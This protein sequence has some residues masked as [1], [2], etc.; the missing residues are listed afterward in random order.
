MDGEV[1]NQT[2]R[3]AQDAKRDNTDA[4]DVNAQDGRTRWTHEMDAQDG[5]TQETDRRRRRTDAGDGQ[6]QTRRIT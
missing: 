5:Q 3:I 4:G 1:N 2:A 6:T